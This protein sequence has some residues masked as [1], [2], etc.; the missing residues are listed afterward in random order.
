MDYGVFV[1]AGGVAADAAG[2]STGATT[3]GVT[4][5]K[6]AGGTAGVGTIKEGVKSVFV[7]EG[8]AVVEG[9]PLVYIK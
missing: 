4:D 2:G 8:T 5:V 7:I 1:V 6:A 3:L 9:H